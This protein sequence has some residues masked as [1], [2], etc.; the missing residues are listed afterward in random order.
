VASSDHAE[1]LIHTDERFKILTEK[2]WPG[3][4]TIIMKSRGVVADVVT[5]GL[6]TLAVR[7]P[8][9][10]IALSLIEK[11][12]LPIAAPSANS[13]GRPSPTKAQHVLS[14]LDGKIPLIIDGGECSF[15]IESTIL[16]LDE[17]GAT[18]LRPGGV[19]LAQIEEVIGKTELSG[20]IIDKVPENVK[21]ESPGQLLRHYSPK[22]PLR[23]VSGEKDKRITF[24]K[25]ASEKGAALL[26]YDDDI[27]LL[28]LPRTIKIGSEN[29]YILQAH[30]LFAALRDADKLGAEII[31][32][33]KP[34]P[35]GVGLALLNRLLRAAGFNVVE[36]R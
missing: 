13:S 2:F 19:T 9:H 36:V 16:K 29:D 8:N 6:P 15:G 11:S 24:M 4:L 34:E 10:P 21:P 22:T 20:G 17:R 28:P 31:Y 26:I 5:A 23:L 18:L 3:P 12:G 14:D 25:D 32:A 30:M 7:C 1:E 33:P 27:E 35:S